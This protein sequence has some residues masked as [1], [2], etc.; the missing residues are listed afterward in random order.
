M[1]KS[2]GVAVI[3]FVLGWSIVVPLVCIW[4]VNTLFGTAI[5]FTF[6]TWLAAAILSTVVSGSG[7]RKE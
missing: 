2:T 6:T 7:A 4:A 5:P 3:V 1:N